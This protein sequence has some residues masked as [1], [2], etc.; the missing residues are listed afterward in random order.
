MNFYLEIRIGKILLSMKNATTNMH[1]DIS[2]RPPLPPVPKPLFYRVF[3]S[4][5]FSSKNK[6]TL[7]LLK[8]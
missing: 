4:A 7:V 6:T 8:Q 2:Q 3:I 1:K 5:P